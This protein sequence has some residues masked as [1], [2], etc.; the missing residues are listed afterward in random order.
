MS[1]PGGGDD[2]GGGN[3][4][5]AVIVVDSDDAIVCPV[6]KEVVKLSERRVERLMSLAEVEH[7]DRE[8]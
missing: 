8:A 5:A 4:A 3:F 2:G 7:V 6:E 1:D